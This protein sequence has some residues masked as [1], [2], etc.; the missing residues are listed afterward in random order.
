VYA[1]GASGNAAPIQTITSGLMSG[2]WGIVLDGAGHFWVSNF[3]AN[4][5]MEFHTTDHGF[6]LPLNTITGG[7][8]Q[9]ADPT[10][11]ARDAAGNLLVANLFGPS[12]L[13]YTGAGPFG[14][15][16]PSFSIAGAADGLGLPQGVDLDAAGRI[17]VADEITGVKVYPAGAATPAAT[18]SGSNTA[19]KTAATIAVSPPLAIDS[20]ALPPAAAGRRYRGLLVAILGRAP[21]RW[22]LLHGHLPAGLALSGSGQITG[23]VNRPGRYRFTVSARDAGTPAQTATATISLVVA[24]APTVARVQPTRGSVHGGATVT[25]T[26]TAFATRAGATTVSFGRIRSP[27]VVCRSHAHC[28]VRTPPGTP[29]TVHVTVTVRGLTSRRSGLDV[30]RYRP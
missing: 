17:Y 8:T 19:I 14:D 4:A 24:R 27:H 3:G 28:T 11:L 1:A 21:I 13:R 6:V 18:I 7:A 5:L 26:G 30:Y 15:A 20:T 2:P 29:G 22:K 9:L 23:I 10:A 16:A 12:V 25:I